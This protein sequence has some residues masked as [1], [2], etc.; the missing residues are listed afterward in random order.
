MCSRNEFNGE[1]HNILSILGSMRLSKK[2]ITEKT[3]R[4][5]LSSGIIM[6]NFFNSMIWTFSLEVFYFGLKKK[7]ESNISF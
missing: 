1:T 4:L 2:I 7:L 6:E 5:N 3:K